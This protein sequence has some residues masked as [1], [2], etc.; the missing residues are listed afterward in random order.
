MEPLI[1]IIIEDNLAFAYCGEAQ[2]DE[3][4]CVEQLERIAFAVG[5]LPRPIIRTF[6]NVLSEMAGEARLAGDSV[7]AD[8][9]DLMPLHMNLTNVTNGSGDD[10]AGKGQETILDNF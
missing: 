9:L 1:R 5:N 6:L 4:F 8:R 10:S 7:T 3:D 2:L